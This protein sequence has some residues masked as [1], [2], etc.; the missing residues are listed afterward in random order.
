[1]FIPR[2]LWMTDWLIAGY[3]A[4][5]YADEVSAAQAREDAR[6]AREDA[7]RAQAAAAQA[8]EDAEIAEANAARAEA[9]ARRCQS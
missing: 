7:E 8:R 6:L 1:M 3:V 5:R 4:D 2:P 9:E